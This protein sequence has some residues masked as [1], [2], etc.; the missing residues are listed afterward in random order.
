MQLEMKKMSVSLH[1]FKSFICP[2]VF[3][4]ALRVAEAFFST[5]MKLRLKVTWDVKWKKLLS[6]NWDFIFLHPA[7]FT[8]GFV[9]SVLC[10]V[11]W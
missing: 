7:F 1:L 4:A 9:H 8:L 5:C 3:V 2:A 10:L 6:N 11:L